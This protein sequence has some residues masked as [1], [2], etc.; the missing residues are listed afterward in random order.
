MIFA[1]QNAFYLENSAHNAL[2]LKMP[3]ISLKHLETLDICDIFKVSYQ[4]PDIE[5]NLDEILP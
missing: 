4:A 3:Q 5:I 2:K 1:H